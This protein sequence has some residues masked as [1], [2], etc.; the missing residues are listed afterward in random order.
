MVSNHTEFVDPEPPLFFKKPAIDVFDNPH[1]QQQPT[2][3]VERKE[4]RQTPSDEVQ[5]N[6]PREILDQT[7]Q[8]N[9]RVA[10]VL[11]KN[12]VDNQNYNSV[13]KQIPSKRESKDKK[14]SKEQKVDNF[15]IMK[16][17]GSPRDINAVYAEL[18]LPLPQSNIP[19]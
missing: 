3:E 2:F 13:P 8:G 10:S 19:S 16:E 5:T 15:R 14:D 1:M 6:A 11:K 9:S 18:G 17:T 4:T 7:T 12:Y